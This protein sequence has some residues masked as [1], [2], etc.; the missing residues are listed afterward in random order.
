RSTVFR[1]K[2]QEVDPPA[3]GRDLNVRAVLTGRIVQRGETLNIQTELID[4]SNESQFWGQQYNRKLS[5]IFALQEQ[6]AREI[7]ERLRLRL[8][9]EEEMRLT[10]RYT[11]NT[12]AYHLYLKGRYH[13]NKRSTE[14]LKKGIDFFEK[15]IEEDPSYAMAYAGLA[16]TYALL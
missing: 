1:Y 15:A 3:V 11:E 6:I 14:G 12:E 9:G 4:V 2:G 5:D 13:W 8:T 7:S 10:K 16:D